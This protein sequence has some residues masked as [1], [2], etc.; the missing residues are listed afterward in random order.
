[1]DSKIPK[2]CRECK[3]NNYCKAYYSGI[4]CTYK[5]DIDPECIKNSKKD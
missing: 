1:M 5:K 2:N 3:N 4:G